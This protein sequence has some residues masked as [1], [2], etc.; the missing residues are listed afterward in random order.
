MRNL[1]REY[2]QTLIIFVFA[3]VILDF[4]LRILLG[5]GLL[6]IVKVRLHIPG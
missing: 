6:E 5:G 1:F 2:F 3:I 4:F